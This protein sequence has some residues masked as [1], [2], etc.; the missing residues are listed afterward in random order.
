M[1]GWETAGLLVRALL[2]ILEWIW[3]L[4]RGR[5]APKPSW[6]LPS[7]TVRVVA[8]P[9]QYQG[10]SWGTAY[11]RGGPVRIMAVRG[12]FHIT[13]IDPDVDVGIIRAD[14]VFRYWDRWLFRR[15]QVGG[16]ALISSGEEY[17]L[18]SMHYPIPRGETREVHGDWAIEPA[19]RAENDTRPFRS[20][21]EPT[22]W[23][24]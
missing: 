8:A 19:F 14:L 1:I 7:M 5:N 16:H 20:E 3:K 11:P 9:E 23:I 12:T 15:V 4:V 10:W 22:S 13:A 2:A 6:A 17:G 24:S 18:W 21:R